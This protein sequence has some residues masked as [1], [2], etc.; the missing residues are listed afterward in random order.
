M[1]GELVTATRDRNELTGPAG[2]HAALPGDP[3][4]GRPDPVT[5]PQV[6][7]ED[8][9]DQGDETGL[10]RVDDPADA[11]DLRCGG[12]DRL[13]QR[14]VRLLHAFRAHM[15]ARRMQAMTTDLFRY[16]QSARTSIETPLHRF[17]HVPTKYGA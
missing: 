11:G 16:F 17:F 10:G 3:V 7:I 9:G 6:L 15:F 14:H 13:R 1:S 4:L 12:V 5:D 8:L 2:G